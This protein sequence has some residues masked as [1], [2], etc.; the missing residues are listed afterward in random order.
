MLPGVCA[1]LRF[2]VEVSCAIGLAEAEETAD[3]RGVQVGPDDVRLTAPWVADGP[4]CAG[5]CQLDLWGHEP[6]SQVPT[7][8]FSGKCHRAH[9]KYCP[10]PKDGL[11]HLLLSL[12]HILALRWQQAYK[13]VI[14]RSG[15]RSG[16]EAPTPRA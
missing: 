11:H 14:P 16:Q 4:V 12:W 8:D 1:A 3:T 10:S 6:L 13:S 7:L 15:S 9:S 5:S 2:S